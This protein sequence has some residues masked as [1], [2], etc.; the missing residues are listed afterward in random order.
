M[1]LFYIF[2]FIT[3]LRI[4]NEVSQQNPYMG[5]IRGPFGTTFSK[6]VF[7]SKFVKNSIGVVPRTVENT[8]NVDNPQ[9]KKKV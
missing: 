1:G 7:F 6:R 8:K 5:G 4:S 9:M 2:V 3:E